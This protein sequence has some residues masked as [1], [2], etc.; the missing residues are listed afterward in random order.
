MNQAGLWF[1]HG[2]DNAT[3]EAAW[4]VLT[5]T[6]QQPD[7]RFSDWGNEVG[8]HDSKAIVDLLDQRIATRKPLAYLLGEAW[9]CGVKFLVNENVLVPRSPIGELIGH[10]Y[11]PWVDATQVNRVLD[12]CTGS[13]CIGIATALAIPAC[14]VDLA[15][16]SQDALDVADSNIRLHGLDKP[17]VGRVK[18]IQSDL[19]DRLE[20][21]K[22][23]LI[24]S[25]PPYVSAMEYDSLPFEYHREP[26]LALVSKLAGLEIPLKILSQSGD[27]LQPDG[28]LICEVGENAEHLQSVLPEVLLTW[29]SFAR[30]AGG[31]FAIAREPLEAHRTEIISVLERLKHVS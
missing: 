16:I 24:V 28:V 13:G 26:E 15:D 23:D 14:H 25:N 12:L 4:L 31:V 3:D 8:E 6:G 9:F 27:F 2:T 30:G 7:G 20:G 11:S 10:Q 29:L 17:H 1:G 18:T 21:R 22:Y 5:A 19:Y